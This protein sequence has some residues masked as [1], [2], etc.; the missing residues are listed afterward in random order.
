MLDQESQAKGMHV[1]MVVH[2][3]RGLPS[4]TDLSLLHK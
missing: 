2:H 3:G 1:T 4:C